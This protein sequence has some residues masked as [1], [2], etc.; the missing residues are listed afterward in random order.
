MGKIIIMKDERKVC[1]IDTDSILYVEVDD[2]LCTFHLYK[3][4]MEG[5]EG[6]NKNVFVCTKSLT[7]VSKELPGH[8]FRI[9]RSCVINLMRMEALIIAE[10][11]VV[12]G[13]GKSLKISCR[14]IKSC[15][16]ALEEITLMG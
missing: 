16:K 4:D 12:M 10:R 5:R 7:E 14:R 9:S 8:F 6:K 2:Y 1:N 15:K 11:E 3:E 13:N